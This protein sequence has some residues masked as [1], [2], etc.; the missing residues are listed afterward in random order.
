M[1]IDVIKRMKAKQ[2]NI[3]S[4][5]S[6]SEFSS[7]VELCATI[8]QLFTFNLQ[9][10]LVCCLVQR[11]FVYIS[12][13]FDLPGRPSDLQFLQEFHRDIVKGECIGFNPITACTF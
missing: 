10:D 7:C 3:F 2:L 9:K 13:I 6:S 1:I 8:I 11:S 5:S 12:R 4:N